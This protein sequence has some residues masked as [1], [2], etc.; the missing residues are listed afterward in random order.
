MLSH[1]FYSQS[2]LVTSASQ[3]TTILFT[4]GL[5]R[6]V[7]TACQLLVIMAVT[8]FSLSCIK[9]N[10]TTVSSQLDISSFASDLDVNLHGSSHDVPGVN[11]CKVG[12]CFVD[13]EDRFLP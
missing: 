4:G 9:L 7:L 3:K 13:V 12:S 5:A 2:K 8:L 10:S 6:L 1:T 11:F